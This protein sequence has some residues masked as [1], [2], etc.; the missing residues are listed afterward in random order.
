MAQNEEQNAADLNA[1]IERSRDATIT[2]H[3]PPSS[4]CTP[5]HGTE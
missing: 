2:I 4:E 3:Y 5:H 1:K